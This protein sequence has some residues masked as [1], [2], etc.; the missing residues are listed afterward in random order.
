MIENGEEVLRIVKETMPN[1]PPDIWQGLE[2]I[3][4]G[5]GPAH[6]TCDHPNG[7]C[8]YE[9]WVSEST[10]EMKSIKLM[11]DQIDMAHALAT[12]L[13]IGTLERVSALDVLD[14]LAVAGLQL[15]PAQPLDP[16]PPDH[17]AG[18][19]ISAAYFEAIRMVDNGQEIKEDRWWI[20]DNDA[21]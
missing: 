5:I 9:E 10:I 19:M 11:W 20:E 4:N 3:V 21:E 6:E 14:S 17:A 18:T 8:A 15:T 13:S 12:E 16:V 7:H 1:L 2:D